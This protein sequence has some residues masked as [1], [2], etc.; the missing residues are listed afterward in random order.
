LGR[1]SD[2]EKRTTVAHAAC[3]HLGGSS[4]HE[5]ESHACGRQ[6]QSARGQGSP[7]GQQL[8]S[9]FLLPSKLQPDHPS[10]GRE[11]NYCS[12]RIGGVLPC[13]LFLLVVVLELVLLLLLLLLWLLLLG[14][15]L[16]FT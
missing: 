11:G 2:N 4:G 16:S 5:P 10:T 6:R 8:G 3:V 1:K 12:E 14:R 7:A 13:S 15:R 9:A